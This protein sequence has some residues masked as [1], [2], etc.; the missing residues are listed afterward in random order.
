MNK[1]WFQWYT[2]PNHKILI[3]MLVSAL[4]PLAD[5]VGSQSV[6]GNAGESVDNAHNVV[7]V[8]ITSGS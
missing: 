4:F 8:G 1:I 2:N 6:V 7:G 3:T 5:G